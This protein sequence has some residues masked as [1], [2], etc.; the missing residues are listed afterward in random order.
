MT[1]PAKIRAHVRVSGLV[2]G[3]GYRWSTWRQ[4]SQL[5]LSGW[6]R[7]RRD[8]RVEAVFEGEPARIEAM[9]HWCQ[10]G[11]PS[12]QVTHVDVEIEPV[13]NLHGFE[14]VD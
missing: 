11:P 2:Q 10:Q 13:E 6:V 1:R 14:I 7:N 5:E 3:V 4:A 12:A 8:G 9:L